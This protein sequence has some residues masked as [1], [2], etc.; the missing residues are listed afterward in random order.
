MILIAVVSSCDKTR[1]YARKGNHKYNKKNYTEAAADYKQ[2][3]KNDSTFSAANYNM[4]NA[5]MQDNGKD[6]ASAVNYYN[7]YLENKNPK[8]PKEAKN[9]SKALY[10]RGN[11]LFGLSQTNKESEDGMKYLSQAAQDYKNAMLLNPNDS[12]AKYN[13]ALC[14]WL[15]K[16]NNNPDNNNDNQNNNS[17]SEINQMLNA[18]KNNEKQTISRVKKQKENVHN[19]QNEKD[20]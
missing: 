12:N 18:M 17:N 16:N 4:G 7:K 11:A 6:Y 20:W 13:Y 14:M 5:L 9:I 19:K 2:A 8:N 1:S 3:L 10:N 15:M